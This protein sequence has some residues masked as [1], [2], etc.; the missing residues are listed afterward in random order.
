MIILPLQWDRGSSNSIGDRKLIFSAD[1]SIDLGDFNP[2][3]IQQGTQFLVMMVEVGTDEADC[4][5]QET[6]EETK[7]RF[8]RH[9]EALVTDIAR[10]KGVEHDEFR[11]QLK[12][13]L[14]QEGVIKE[15]TSEMSLEE[16]AKQ[17]VK[18][19]AIKFD[20]MPKI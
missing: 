15:S 10:M 12:A 19:R 3:K 18:L 4:F 17:I 6:K 14:I 2:F 5:A 9:F 7:T 1:P 13:S 8:K 11:N 20:L 16:Y